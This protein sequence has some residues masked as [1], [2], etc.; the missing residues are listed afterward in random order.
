M[1]GIFRTFA[2]AFIKQWYMNKREDWLDYYADAFDDEEA[3]TQVRCSIRERDKI[4]YEKRKEERRRLKIS[5]RWTYFKEA[6]YLSAA[7]ATI[8]GTL[9]LF[10]V[11]T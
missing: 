1:P 5:K 11:F 10:G 3:N 9:Y 6:V 4:E 8:L 7:L 2:P